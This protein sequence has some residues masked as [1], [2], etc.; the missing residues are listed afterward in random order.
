MGD[1]LEVF[2]ARV[3]EGVPHGFLG[4]SGGVSTGEV[5]GLQIGLGAGDAPDAV[6]ENRRRAAEAVCSGCDIVTVYQIHSANVVTVPRPW[7]DRERPRADAMVTDEP[8]MLLGIVTADCAP[9][10]FADR[11]AGVIGAAHAGWRGA[12]GGVLENT[13]AA[14]VDLGASPGNIAAAI[15]PAIGQVSYEVDE[16]FRTQFDLPDDR[17]FAPGRPEHWQFD[18]PAYAAARLQDAGVGQVERLDL[19]TYANPELF[20]SYRRATH[21]GRPAYGRQFSLIS[22]PIYRYLHEAALPS[23]RGRASGR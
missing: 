15:G 20:Y 13:V 18:L 9:V 7:H 6:A 5:A 2:R 1:L 19:D 22:L 16:A 4:R 23:R 11:D 3:L 10:L 14:M 12:L 21:E 8:D 17:F